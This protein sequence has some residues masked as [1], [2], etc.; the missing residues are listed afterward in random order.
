MTYACPTW[1]FAADSL[2]FE[3]QRLQNKVL[4]TTGNLARCTPTSGLRVAFKIPYIYDFVTKLC[5]QQTEV[6][7]N[8]ETVNFR[9]IAQDDV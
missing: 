1:E 2:S 4:W 6:M 8:H 5:R 3:L 9:N 7:L